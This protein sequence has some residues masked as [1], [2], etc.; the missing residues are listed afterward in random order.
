VNSISPFDGSILLEVAIDRHTLHLRLAALAV[1]IVPLALL[2]LEAAIDDGE[3][4]DF[5]ALGETLGFAADVDDCAACFVAL[6]SQ[7]TMSIWRKSYVE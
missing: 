7:S 2:A 3:P 5:L 4:A 6:I 1:Q